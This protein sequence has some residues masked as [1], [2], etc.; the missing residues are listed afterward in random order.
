MERELKTRGPVLDEKG[1]PIPG[2]SR[3]STLVYN[4]NAIK[5]P[6][7][8]I[9]EWDF[10]Q[11]SNDHLCLQLTIG[12]AAYAGQVSLMLFD[13]QRGKKYLDLSRILPLPFGSLHMPA[14][15]E[16]DHTLTYPPSSC[17]PRKN[18]PSRLLADR[19]TTNVPD[20]TPY[21]KDG[22]FMSF[23]THSDRRTLTCR[24]KDLEAVI[25]LERTN[26]DSLVI[27][28]PFNE[29]DHAFYYNQKINCM[30]AEGFVRT[31]KREWTFS[32]S[33][34]FGILDWGRG[35]WP[36]HNEWYWSNGSGRLNGEMFGFNL[37]CG[38]GNTDTASENMLFYKGRSHKLGKVDFTLGSSYMEP[39]HLT[40]REGRL[41]LTLT[42]V[43]DRTT[44]TRLLWVDNCCHQMFGAFSG[45]AVL[46]DGTALQI[47]NIYS[48][49]EH[50]V[51]NW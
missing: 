17:S 43:Y 51:N 1:R 9:K 12:H 19:R 3:K 36:F 27:N 11:I 15:A 35:V 39:W 4:R 46:D 34:S 29:Y 44:K 31:R 21:G 32:R 47:K 45:T 37:G 16:L 14:D 25:H 26:P 5:A 7:W 18:R 23:D 8:R 24:W 40:D 2:Y 13:F 30:T 50:A 22:V 10:Y 20:R 49:A 33:D 38:F 28:L 6:P 48:F 41:N 42:P